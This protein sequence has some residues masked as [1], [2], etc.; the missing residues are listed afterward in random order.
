MRKLKTRLNLRTKLYN[1]PQA[2][3]RTLESVFHSYFYYEHISCVASNIEENTYGTVSFHLSI[4]SR[5]ADETTYVA[6]DIEK[7]TYG[8]TSF[9][10][11]I[12]SGAADEITNV[13]STVQ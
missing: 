3:N 6:I 2:Q 10:L 5:A 13:V 4:M 11:S 9:H 1:H 8:T 7:K 12:T